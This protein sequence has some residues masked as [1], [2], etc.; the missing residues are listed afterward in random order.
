MLFISGKHDNAF[1]RIHDLMSVSRAEDKMSYCYIQV[2]RATSDCGH[3]HDYL[4]L[5]S[6]ENVFFARRLCK[7]DSG[8]RTL[9]GTFLICY[10][11]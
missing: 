9:A 6:W 1:S 3:T 7:C 10:R 2:L 8:T 4:F 11:Q 5:D